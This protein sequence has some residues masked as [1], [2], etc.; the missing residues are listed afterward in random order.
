MCN[1]FYKHL[2]DNNILYRKQ[3]GFQE[4][5]S[6]KHVIM[7]L[8]DQISSSFERNLYALGVF[9]ELSK[10]FET[11]DHKILIT[12]LENYGVKETN[13]DGLKAI[14]EIVNN[15]LHMKIFRLLILTFHVVCH[16]VQFLGHYSRS[17]MLL[18]DPIMSADD[19]NI[20]HSHQNT[21]PFLETLNCELQKICGWFRAKKLFLNVTKINYTLFHKNST[22]NKLPIKMSKLKI[23]NSIIKK[24]SLVKFLG[25]LLD[26]NILWKNH[27]KLIEKKL[28][29]N[30]G[31]LYCAKPYLDE[32]SLKTI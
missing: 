1:R 3:F 6:T 18:L 11:L 10:A 12:K 15:S 7:Q 29:K 30:V 19:T 32:A 8:V 2:S 26:E 25:V 27:I 22:K 9:I 24:K 16:K 13:L 28:G 14:L 4:K 5:H 20:F 21:K 23:G 31:L 17:Q